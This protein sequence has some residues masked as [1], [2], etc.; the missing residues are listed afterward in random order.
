MRNRA[1]WITILFLCLFLSGCV[2]LKDPETSLEY[3]ADVVGTLSSD[4]TLGQTLVSRRPGINSVQLW[5]RETSPPSSP[6]E[7][8]NFELYHSPQET[9]PLVTVPI[10][11]SALARSFPLTISFPPQ[12]DPPGQSYYLLLKT[13]TGSVQVLGR[14]EDVYPGGQLLVNGVPQQADAAFR[15]SYEYGMPAMLADLRGNISQVWLLLP[16]LIVLWLPG[17]LLLSLCSDLILSG[18]QPLDWGQRTALSIGLSLA[19]VPLVMLWTSMLGLRWNHTSVVIAALLLAGIYLWRYVR[20]FRHLGR[21]ALTIDSRGLLLFGIFLFSLAIRLVMV[22]D[23][24]APAWVDPV[25]H[26]TIVR[27]IIEKGSFPQEYT[28][29]VETDSAG[30]HPGF[31]S[32]VASF[33]WLSGLDIAPAMLLLGQVLN[34]LCVL[35]VY[36]FTTTF[37]KDRTAGLIA[38]LI[39]AVFSPMPAYYASWGRYT[40]L[41]GLLILPASMALF[42]RLLEYLW[43]PSQGMKSLVKD[44]KILILLGSITCGGLAITHYRVIMFLSALLVA[45]LFAQTLQSLNKIPLWQTIPLMVVL[46]GTVTIGA[47]LLTLPWW[48]TFFITTIAPKLSLAQPGAQPLKIDWGYLTPIYG[49]QV[50]ILAGVGL[51]W[52]IIRA[53]WFGLTMALWIGLLFMIANQGIIHLPGAGFV[54]KTSVEITLFMPL[55]LLGGYLIGCLI[56]TGRKILPIRYHTPYHLALIFAAA[57]LALLGARSMIPILNP[58]TFLFREADKPALVWIRENL[59]S[60]ETILINPFLWNKGVYA[61][62]DGGYWITPMIGQKSLPPPVLYSLGDPQEI[63]RINQICQQVIDQGKNPGEL[64]ELLQ[65]Q[66]IRYIFLGARGGVLSPGA[67]QSSPLFRL[68]YNQNG[69]WIF[70]LQ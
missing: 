29:Y 45:Y 65:A 31:H 30:Y 14:M 2:T 44:Q 16:L 24:A 50:M 37:T 11:F 7:V 6:G 20:R 3:T 49:K 27:V 51:A 56:H 36:L 47:V 17:R 55:S 42:T 32:V 15:S 10:T 5:M 54:N 33:H 60:S 58:V 62:Q 35:A 43:H 9:Q 68:M 13:Q 61:G 26:A 23:L 67:L 34:A 25:H 66:N 41:T 38:A 21:R 69:V 18:D 63:L 19:L 48:P 40:Q 57:V 53:R 39:T 46:T 4:Q 59:P 64:Y 70:K 28:P 12:H 1:V 22:R 52:S 8:I